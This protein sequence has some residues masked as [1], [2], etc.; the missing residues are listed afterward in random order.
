MATA[1]NVTVTSFN[2]QD[3]SQ[4]VGL[5]PAN[6]VLGVAKDGGTELIYFNESKQVNDIYQIDEDPAAVAALDATNLETGALQE[7]NGNSQSGGAAVLSRF[8]YR[9]VTTEG[10]DTRILLNA[11]NVRSTWDVLITI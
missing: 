3:R 2:S 10:A 11:G 8:R 9:E 6:I 4:T 7:L 5:N 1:I